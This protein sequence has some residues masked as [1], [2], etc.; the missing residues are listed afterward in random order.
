MFLDGPHSLT[1]RRVRPDLRR[2]K[3]RLLSDFWPVF[4]VKV[5]ENSRG[6]VWGGGVWRWGEHWLS[7]GVFRFNI[8]APS[9]SLSLKL[10]SLK[11]PLSRL[12]NFH[13]LVSETSTI[14]STLKLP[15]SLPLVSLKLPPSRLWNYHYLFHTETST[16]SST[17]PSLKLAL[18][19][20]LVPLKLGQDVVA[21]VVVL[22]MIFLR[23]R[24]LL[25]ASCM[26][27]TFFRWLVI[28]ALC[29][30][31]CVCVC[32]WCTLCVSVMH[33]LCVCVCTL[34]CCFKTFLPSSTSLMQQNVHFAD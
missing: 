18:S 12:W 20:P 16:I 2:L 1:K 25:L 10:V 27:C 4:K 30:T 24:L 32:L 33:S 19:L 29:R 23:S 14:S 26:L 34:N 22:G 5:E 8:L 21:L 31:K 7:S 15:L 3:N 13:Y 17:F 11:L 9:P 28:E 6:W